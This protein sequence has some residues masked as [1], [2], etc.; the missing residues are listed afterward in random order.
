[1]E[2]QSSRSAAY[3]LDF[4]VIESEDGKKVNARQYV[5]HLMPG[6]V[7]QHDLKI[8]TR[9]P[10]EAKQ[11]DLQY[12]DVGTNIWARV[13]ESEDGLQLDARADLSRLAENP[14]VRTM[15]AVEQFQIAGST[16]AVL[17]KPMVLGIVDDPGAKRQFQ[18][19][20]TV[21]RLR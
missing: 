21:T 8:G 14:G 19:A 12:L 3:R 4:E 17:G 1:M 16:L 5:M 20:V 13:S 11:G 10:V 6:Y 15:P 18:L 7:A 9:I 2:T